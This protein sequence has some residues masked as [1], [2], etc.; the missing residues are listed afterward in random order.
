M[1]SPEWATRSERGNSISGN[2]M[3]RWRD[4]LNLSG[5]AEKRERL[6]VMA[7]VNSDS[8]ALQG[9]L[10]LVRDGLEAQP[11]TPEFGGLYDLRAA[12]TGNNRAVAS[13][14]LAAASPRND[15]ACS[16]ANAAPASAPLRSDVR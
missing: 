6:D 3:S 5:S 12:L 4:T 13:W 1:P 11:R 8:T 15:H 9:C 7:M 16:R 14:P 2:G 10:R